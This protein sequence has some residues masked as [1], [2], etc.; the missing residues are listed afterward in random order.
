MNSDSSSFLIIVLVVIPGATILAFLVFRAIVLW[1]WKISRIV[2]LLEIV[3]AEMRAMNARGGGAERK[4]Q[5]AVPAQSSSLAPLPEE[6]RRGFPWDRVLNVVA[7][8]V[9]ALFLLY[10][11]IKIVAR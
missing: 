11:L 10:V 6:A 7:G 3:A 9:I 5:T 4:G 1:Y 2:E 8:V